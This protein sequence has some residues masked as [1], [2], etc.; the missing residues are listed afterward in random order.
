[1][2]ETELAVRIVMGAIAIRIV[3]EVVAAIW[4]LVKIGSSL[5]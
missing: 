5:R 3:M 2:V 1:M 4:F